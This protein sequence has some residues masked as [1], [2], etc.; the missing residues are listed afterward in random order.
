MADWRDTFY[1]RLSSTDSI[2]RAKA[3]K[4]TTGVELFDRV[5]KLTKRAGRNTGKRIS[6]AKSSF[7]TSTSKSKANLGKNIDRMS[8][9]FSDFVDRRLSA[10]STESARKPGGFGFN[11]AA[12]LDRRN[13]LNSPPRL[14]ATE[15]GLGIDPSSV[16]QGVRDVLNQ[17]LAGPSTADPRRPGGF[18][19]NP[20]ARLGSSAR[21]SAKKRQEM[22]ASYH[23]NSIKS[24]QPE[25]QEQ[26]KSMGEQ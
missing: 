22:Q 5:D 17:P 2:S 13:Q 10:P 8:A 15:V 23:P 3:N 25:N 12:R 9:A 4:E 20:A 21:D 14:P 7:N 11:P 26:A 24:F 19:F 16:V 18:G 1:D 6:K